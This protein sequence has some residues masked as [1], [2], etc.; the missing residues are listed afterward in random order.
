MAAIDRIGFLFHNP[1]LINHLGGVIELL[2]AGTFDLLVCWDAE[3]SSE[4]NE[5]ARRWGAKL[6]TT[7]EVI[8]SGD[9]YRFLVSNHPVHL[10][11]RP[12]IQDLA[13][14]NIRFMYAAGK[15]GWNLSAWNNLYD[16]I[17]CFGPFHAAAFG[18]CSDAVVLQ[19]GYPRFDR[20]FDAAVNLDQLRRKFNCD[21]KK[22][23]I[24]WLPT[25]S[26]LSSIG[27]FD[28]EVASLMET[29]N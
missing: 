12:L 3:N 20:F 1:E 19:M 9:R 8:Q 6:V 22:K 17:L 15:S 5:A 4:M 21:P 25:W 29:Y 27:L 13:E 28:Q 16:L 2:P 14:R 7:S 10:H 18:D 23:T 24:V 26:T 11:P